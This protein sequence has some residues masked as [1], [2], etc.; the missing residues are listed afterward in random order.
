MALR[1][2]HPDSRR[3]TKPRSKGRSHSSDPVRDVAETMISR[4]EAGI[5]AA[6]DVG[7]AYLKQGRETLEGVGGR[8]VNY[9]H[10]R[11]LHA[12]AIAAGAGAMLAFFIRRR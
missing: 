11:P 7:E 10:D 3:A 5:E 9:I 8:V 2:G 6:Q 12:L 1:N 4:A